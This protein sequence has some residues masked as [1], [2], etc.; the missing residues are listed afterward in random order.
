MVY[1]VYKI[2]FRTKKGTWRLYVGYTGQAKVRRAFHK[3]K[4]PAWVKCQR[5]DGKPIWKTPETGIKSKEMALAL[6]AYHASRAI[7]AEPN[8]ARGGPWLRPTLKSE[9]ATEALL[10]SKMTLTSLLAY[11]ESDG[12]RLLQKHLKNLEFGPAGDAPGNAAVARGVYLVKRRSGVCGNA[13]RKDRIRKGI[14]RKGS[15]KYRQSKRGAN[16]ELRRTVEND[17]LSKRK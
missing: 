8:I 10:A 2:K 6:E 3:K 17:K 14:L 9:H 1:I 15:K 5:P 16:P 12:S 13:G 7:A 4:P 11:A